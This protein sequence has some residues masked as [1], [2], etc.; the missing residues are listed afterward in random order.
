MT[1]RRAKT[2]FFSG[3]DGPL[4]RLFR[5]RNKPTTQTYQE[6][7]DAV[8]FINDS[9]D[10]A[11]ETQQ[12]LVQVAT[13]VQYAAGTNTAGSKQLVPT[14]KQIK[15]Q[16][17]LH[18]T[19]IDADAKFGISNWEYGTGAGSGSKVLPTYH[20]RTTTGVW[21]YNAGGGAIWSTIFDPTT[22]LGTSNIETGT[23]AASGAR[24]VL[25][26]YLDLATGNWYENVGAGGSVWTT[27]FTAS[28][29]F[30]T[31]NFESGAGAP[32][33]AKFVRTYYTNT[34]N[35]DL[36]L[37][38]GAGA[39][40]WSKIF[41]PGTLYAV[42]D[43]EYGS[44]AGA[45][46]KVLPTYHLDVDTGN[47]TYNA[48]GGA[49]WSTIFNAANVLGTTNVETGSGAP[50]GAKYVN[51]Y[52]LDTATGIWY[53]NVGAGGAI[54]T[55]EYDPSAT[56]QSIVEADKTL[57]YF[58]F[59]ITDT[60][61]LDGAYP[62]GTVNFPDTLGST[63]C[64]QV[65]DIVAKLDGAAYIDGGSVNVVEFFYNDGGGTKEPIFTLENTLFVN[66]N[67]VEYATKE[68]GSEAQRTMFLNV[69]IKYVQNDNGGACFTHI[70]TPPH[71]KVR[72]YY[73]VVEFV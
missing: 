68:I 48:G 26:Y 47:W 51:T 72:V 17:A 22:I 2:Y 53:N 59:E 6:L 21:Y 52:Y 69:L 10:T 32:S 4:A 45:G 66:N 23:G 8:A 5:K 35:G 13:D 38:A 64:F 65:V 7:C 60:F 11:M 30:G 28:Q 73:R 29:V 67:R 43:I 58:D 44:G 49:F 31:V 41:S 20:L 57:D 55:T 3:S 46:S 40:L 15:D 62:E 70:G 19:K 71:V 25:T 18:Y 54:W 56:F 36:Y 63:K 42:S 33:G 34:A 27:V 16:F 50:A 24:N 14:N 61:L 9:G 37:N 39:V 12:G 1:T